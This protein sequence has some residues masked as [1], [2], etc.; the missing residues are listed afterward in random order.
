VNQREQHR[1]HHQ[2]VDWRRGLCRV[3]AALLLALLLALLPDSS[4]VLAG[5][6]AVGAR[7]VASSQDGTLTIRDGERVRVTL[8]IGDVRVRTQAGGSVQYRLRVEVPA[9][10][11]PGGAAPRF[12][13][14]ARTEPEGAVLVG[15]TVKGRSPDHYWVTLELDVPRNTPL[16]VSTQGGNI[17]VGD[18]DARL[19]CETAGGKIRVGRVGAPARLQT[20]GGD[21]VV[22]DV[23]GDL[24]AS[25]GGGNILA[26][27]VS[28][29]ATLHSD[30]GHIRVASVAGEARVDT[31]G[32][33]IFLERAGARLI[34]STGG[35]RI[36]VGEA[37]GELSAKTVGG[38][39]RVWRL[40]GPATINTGAGSI[41]LAGVTS[42]VRASTA[43]G[44]I[45]AVFD[46]AAASA[47]PAPTTP[48]QRPKVPRGPRPDGTLGELQ[49]NG[50][51]LV[52]FV[53]KGLALNLDAAIEGG[54][55][56]IVVDPAFAL[57][58]KT[59]EMVRGK[60]FR[61]EGVM[62]GGGP[63]LRLRAT[64]G[65]ILLRPT[66]L[67][68]AMALQALPPLPA[69]AQ[70]Q[71]VLPVQ[72]YRPSQNMD[73]VFADLERSVFDMQRQIESR[74]Q[75]LEAYTSAQELQAQRTAQRYA[76]DQ[77]W[78][79]RKVQV[80]TFSAGDDA[81][82]EYDGSSQQLAQVDGLREKVASLLT[83]RVILSASQLRPLLV[84]RVDP[85]YPEKAK[86]AGI[87]GAVRLRVAISREGSIEDVQALSGEPLLAE[88]AIA[89]VRQWRY[90]PTVLNGRQVPVLTVLTITF[91]RP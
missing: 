42:P 11:P 88:S 3:A 67:P 34:T 86:A 5:P 55:Y 7:R 30:G 21:V 83:D 66:N 6:G 77:R 57:I 90:R 81:N 2:P 70:V 8:E 51:D 10:N 78:Q 12:Q 60:L 26:G 72:P 41:F 16:E 48:A 27:A 53:P 49:C 32:G 1:M 63:L 84:H 4:R 87:E 23:N 15:R 89:A 64:A 73:I 71:P 74:Q 22:Q 69:I 29:N 25:T 38:G 33:N 37:A 20:A 65:N 61:A 44:G 91:H 36:I 39:V 56:G 79:Q 46:A 52:V 82:I 45:T 14:N 35:G 40:A 50:G 17:D 28:G 85:Q 19:L 43:A 76:E 47:P 62:G 59:N 68:G 75:Q 9:A 13:L 18:I 58:L 80:W 31:G 24:N 54:D